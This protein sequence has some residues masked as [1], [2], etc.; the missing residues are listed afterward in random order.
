MP[1]T[2]PFDQYTQRYEEWFEKNSLAYQSELRAIKEL[3]PSDGTGIEI[4]V[5]TGRF[6]EP[7]GIE[8]GVEPSFEMREIAL[9]HGIDVFN[10]TAEDIPFDDV[11]FDFA[12]LV[13][14]ICFLDNIHAALHETNRVIRSGGY[15]IVGFIDKNSPLGKKYQEH[16]NESDFYKDATF[17][18][19]EEV[20]SYLIEAGFTNLTY[21]Q[22]LFHSTEKLTAIEPVEDGYGQGAFVVVRGEK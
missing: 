9:E 11:T 4:G 15:I 2:G 7:L 17:Y 3:M 18:S 6:A 14:T 20:S 21:R 13:T 19:A 10:G 16:K 1:K 22:T 12:L 5:G 8:F